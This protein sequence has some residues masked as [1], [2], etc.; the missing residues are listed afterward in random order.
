MTRN[1]A[2]DSK[3]DMIDEY[4]IQKNLYNASYGTNKQPICP[5][6]ILL[7]FI[8]G[9]NETKWKWLTQLYKKCD[10]DAKKAI[11]TINGAMLDTDEIGLI[12]MEYMDD[13]VTLGQYPY[14]DF[15]TNEQ[16]VEAEICARYEILRLN[17]CYGYVH[18]DIHRS[19]IMISYNPHT[20]SPLK[21]YIIDF[22][23]SRKIALEEL[24]KMRNT[25]IAQPLGHHLSNIFQYE[26]P[27]VKTRCKY[28]PL[29]H[30]NA[31]SI[32][33]FEEYQK[34]SNTSS[35]Q[36]MWLYD[37]DAGG[38]IANSYL[39]MGKWTSCPKRGANNSRL[40]QVNT[41]APSRKSTSTTM[42]PIINEGS[43]ELSNLA[44]TKFKNQPNWERELYQI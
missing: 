8:K 21:A 36:Y 35:P 9:T 16:I 41:L 27:I 37:E 19:N 17:Y 20:H 5:S 6:P 31:S 32:T 29:L 3:K 38:P 23:R 40:I 10:T 24:A 4:H 12:Y 22:G 43:K 1:K 26:Q 42:R 30:N 2:T 44:L 33:S 18:G 13:S 14:Q 15:I 7:D 11:Y 39:S 25:I 28:Y 34:R